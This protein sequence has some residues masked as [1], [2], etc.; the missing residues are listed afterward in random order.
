MVQIGPLILEAACVK[1]MGHFDPLI[2]RGV[3]WVV[4]IH[5]TF[6]FVVRD[7]RPATES[8]V[9][10]EPLIFKN[11]VPT[12]RKSGSGRCDHHNQVLILNT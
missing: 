4:F 12:C 2:G 7:A 10:F 1:S 6:S 11:I 5:A 3:V 8:K 9:H